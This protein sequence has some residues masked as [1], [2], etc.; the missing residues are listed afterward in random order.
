LHLEK[1]AENMAILFSYF[2]WLFHQQKPPENKLYSWQQTA[3]NKAILFSYFQRLFHQ[4][5]PP[6][7]KHSGN[8]LYLAA[9]ALFSVN[10]L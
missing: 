10:S 2:Q 3:E 6:E 4:Q 7:N 1:T 8:K 9:L 5:K